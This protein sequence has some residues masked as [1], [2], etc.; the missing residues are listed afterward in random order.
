MV[1]LASGGEDSSVSVL[2]SVG[3]DV[4]ARGGAMG[5]TGTGDSNLRGGWR[6]R[7]GLGGAAL[8]EVG[9]TLGSCVITAGG[10]VGTTGTV[11]AAALAAFPAENLPLVSRLCFLSPGGR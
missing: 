7:L 1:C 10:W 6:L 2:C 9:S 3:G 11:D 4:L 8:I 5:R